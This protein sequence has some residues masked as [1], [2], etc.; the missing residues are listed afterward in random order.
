MDEVVGFAMLPFRVRVLS[1]FP[2]PFLFPFLLLRVL[3]FLFLFG[4]SLFLCLS[5]FPEVRSPLLCLSLR[6][7]LFVVGSVSFLGSVFVVR[8]TSVCCGLSSKNFVFVLILFPLNQ[9][10]SGRLPSG[11]L[12]LPECFLVYLS[13]SFSLLSLLPQYPWM[14][15]VGCLRFSP[16]CLQSFLQW[17][18][19]LRFCLLL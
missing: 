16:R 18:W 9:W 10:K 17:L 3:L 6:T 15:R 1:L 4:S 2:F 19:G 7:V 5:R 14:F 8:E 13:W 11:S 12:G